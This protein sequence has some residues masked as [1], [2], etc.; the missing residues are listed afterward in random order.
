[1]HT[2][3]DIAPVGQEEEVMIPL[4]N[5]V[6]TASRIYQLLQFESS[7]VTNVNLANLQTSAVLGL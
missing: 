5:A 1:M 4:P 6:T 2:V 3:G 7:D